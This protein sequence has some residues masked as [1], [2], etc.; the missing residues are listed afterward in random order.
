MLTSAAQAKS[1]LTAHFES[2]RQCVN[3]A[4]CERLAVLQQ[5]VDDAV[6][7]SMTPL[8]HCEQE[9]QQRVDLAVHILDAGQ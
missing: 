9:I 7:E 3:E 5:S 8:Q 1:K 6:Q 4:L 2:L